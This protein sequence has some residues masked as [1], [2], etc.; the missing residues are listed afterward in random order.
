MESVSAS[1]HPPSS[2]PSEQQ[3]PVADRREGGPEG[4]DQN[5]SISSSST[6]RRWHRG[7]GPRAAVAGR[8][9]A[10][11]PRG[12]RSGQRG[13]RGFVYRAVQREQ[14]PERVEGRE[15][16]QREEVHS[17]PMQTQRGE[18]DYREGRQEGRRG[19]AAFSRPRRP[20]RQWCP[21]QRTDQPQQHQQV[22]QPAAG[23]EQQ[24]QVRGQEG[25]QQRPLHPSARPAAPHRGQQRPRNLQGQRQPQQSQHREDKQQQQG[26]QQR[27]PEDSQERQSPTQLQ[28]VQRQQQQP[29]QPRP[30][31]PVASRPQLSTDIPSVVVE[32]QRLSRVYADSFRLLSCHPSLVP[33]LQQHTLLEKSGDALRAQVAL[34][35][36]RG[37]TD[38]KRAEGSG[39][40]TNSGE[41]DVREEAAHAEDC[42]GLCSFEL[43]FVPTDPDFDTTALPSGLRLHISMG[44]D[45]PGGEE[46]LGSVHREP[47]PPE[48]S[49]K[50]STACTQSHPKVPPAD[51]HDSVEDKGPQTSD[52]GPPSSLEQQHLKRAEGEGGSAQE[53]LSE[54]RGAVVAGESQV[55]AK[56]SVG[57]MSNVASLRVCNREINDF[58]RN[59]IEM[60]FA[61][62][63]EKQHKAQQKADLVRSALRLL[64]RFLREIFE[65]AA[66]TTL[67]ATTEGR[68][69]WTLAEQKRLEEA[70]ILFRRVADPVL[71]WRNISNHVGSRSAKECAMRFKEC[72]ENVLKQRESEAADEGG[73]EGESF[74]GSE[75]SDS[76]EVVSPVNARQEGM[77][78]SP[79]EEGRTTLL[80]GCDISLLEPH[81]EGVASLH[82]SCV[83]LQVA[84]GRCRNPV[85]MRVALPKDGETL[86]TAGCSVDCEKCRL[87]MSV[88]VQPA[89]GI[90]GNSL[91]RVASMEP[92]D[93]LPKDL[94]PCD[95]ILTCDCCGASMKAREVLS[96]APRTHHC[97]HCHSKLTFGF[98]G[99]ALGTAV[100]T[101][102]GGAQ[103]R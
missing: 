97:R 27:L 7:R 15:C 77:Q 85:D 11:A 89:I 28:R 20:Q 73:E 102:L 61:K 79:G 81:T 9:S 41:A 90:C 54:S 50:A 12:A 45:Y 4:V 5:T 99:A 88:R 32:L 91:M 96:G 48:Q 72:R 17:A 42:E 10:S 100:V 8:S 92:C 22:V 74:K 14:Q 60:L 3:A 55:H 62:G 19:G 46:V 30:P 76:E 21:V 93:C 94:L 6:S 49:G 53:K 33:L 24:Q 66:N 16:D 47:A 40:A 23:S 71:R 64:D 38:V 18:I 1:I 39:N 13:S 29:E 58:R 63:T 86:E 65:M 67:S 31:R 87:R 69:A 103:T 36:A 57:L 2:Q 25:R 98:Q 95:F 83:R 56:T 35:Q 44:K 80:R 43:V 68:G 78:P 34:L 52:G 59:A 51:P 70:V 84:C 26:R 37:H 75:Q 82:L 101:G